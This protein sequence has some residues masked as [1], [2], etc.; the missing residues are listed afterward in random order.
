LT[1]EWAAV[2]VVAAVLAVVVTSSDIESAA[3]GEH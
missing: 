3:V 2:A 1:R